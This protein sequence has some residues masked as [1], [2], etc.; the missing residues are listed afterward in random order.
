MSYYLS[1]HI[2]QAVKERDQYKC[3]DCGKEERIFTPS[4]HAARRGALHVHHVIERKNGGTDDPDNLVTLCAACHRRRDRTHIARLRAIRRT[5][6]R[7]ERRA[8]GVAN[9]NDTKEMMGITDPQ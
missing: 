1:N 7:A 9:M 2:K 5:E 6:A 8:R 3:A 4:A